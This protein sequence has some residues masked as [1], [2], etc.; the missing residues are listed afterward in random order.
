MTVVETFDLDMG[1]WCQQ[2]GCARDYA[3]W[4]PL[5]EGFYCMSHDPLTPVRKHDCVGGPAELE[6]SE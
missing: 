5:C 6:E 1:V 2:R 3:T 4:C